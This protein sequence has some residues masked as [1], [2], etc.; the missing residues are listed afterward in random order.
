MR[1]PKHSHNKT[2]KDV[3]KK[4]TSSPSNWATHLASTTAEN[5]SSRGITYLNLLATP[6]VAVNSL[7]HLDPDSTIL[8]IDKLTPTNEQWDTLSSY[9]T[10]V[11]KLYVSSGPAEDWNDTSFPLAWPLDVLVVAGPAS[12]EVLTPAIIEGRVEH[13]AFYLCHNLKWYGLENWESLEDLLP[14]VNI[15]EAEE[16]WVLR[17]NGWTPRKLQNGMLKQYLH[18]RPELKGKLPPTKTK[19]FEIIGNNAIGMLVGFC[20]QCFPVAAGL[21]SVT[22]RSNDYGGVGGWTNGNEDAPEEVFFATFLLTMEKLKVLRLDVGERLLTSENGLEMP[23]LKNMWRFLPPK[24]EQLH[25]RGPVGM[26]SHVEEWVEAFR[27]Q[28]FLPELKRVSF[29]LDRAKDGE[30][31]DM[32]ALH[33]ARDACEKLRDVLAARGVVVEEF[34]DSW[35]F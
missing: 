8:Y 2:S 29:V 9:F 28:K 25:F 1:N 10:K 20:L 16:K 23:L 3:P 24:L 14:F 6:V 27:D 34:P 4:S 13:L 22:L 7:S 31:V 12:A 11:Q 32:E 5:A 19:T 21:E 33:Q 15:G 30:K 35:E 18:A 26:A 17:L